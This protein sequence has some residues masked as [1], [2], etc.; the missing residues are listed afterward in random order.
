M[1]KRSRF[2]PVTTGP[3]SLLDLAAG[4][5]F[6]AGLFPLTAGIVAFVGGIAMK[7][8]LMRVMSGSLTAVAYGIG[9]MWV[10]KK[11]AQGEKVGGFIALALTVMGLFNATEALVLIWGC[12][13]LLVIALIW[14]NL[15]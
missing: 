6:L 11:L 13:S 15:D 9:F 3:S 4:Y 7:L 12:L 5:F 8:P 2:A 10:G 14:R 1:G